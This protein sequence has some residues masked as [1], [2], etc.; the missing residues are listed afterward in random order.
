M[1]RTFVNSQHFTSTPDILNSIKTLFS[2]VLR[3]TENPHITFLQTM[4]GLY[5]YAAEDVDMMTD[6]GSLTEEIETY[7]LPDGYGSIF[8]MMLKRWYFLD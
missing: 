7:F 2:D 6:K 5:G 8:L 4:T 3:Q 1:L